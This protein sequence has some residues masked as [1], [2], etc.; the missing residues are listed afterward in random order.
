MDGSAC[1]G[2]SPTREVGGGIAPHPVSSP[3]F[4]RSHSGH[5]HAHT[6]VSHCLSHT[7][8]V[9]YTITLGEGLLLWSTSGQRGNLVPLLCDGGDDTAITET[10]WS[11]Y[12][13]L[14]LIYF[15]ARDPTPLARRC[16][17]PPNHLTRLPL[18]CP[19]SALLSPFNIKQNI[20][21]G[22]ESQ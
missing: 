10:S 3:L 17:S 5:T 19:P 14:C 6:A 12:R 2:S 16:Q 7:A 1:T 9:L 22:N 13:E 21:L 15:P 20:T 8:E 11:L 18:H 4:S